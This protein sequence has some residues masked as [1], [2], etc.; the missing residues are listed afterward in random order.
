MGISI[1]IKET[2]AKSALC[3]ELRMNVIRVRVDDISG[4]EDL[5]GYDDIVSLDD[6]K[7]QVGDWEAFLK[8]NR[9]NAETDAIYMDKL[10]NEDDIK[11]LKPKAVRTSTG[12]IEMEKVSGAKKDKV[13]AASKKENRLTGWDMLSFEE[14]TEMCQKC[15]IS[16]DKGRGCIGTFGPNDSLLPS[17]AEKK[18]CKIIASVPDGAKSGR[19]YTPNEAK[20]LLKEIEILTAALP[21]EGKMMVRRYG[22]TLER[23]NAVANISVSE[24]CG[25]YFF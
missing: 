6:A 12:W 21:E 5:V 15:K 13:L 20:E 10:K 17:I 14:M 4:M 1:G 11:L 25:F 2:E 7:S 24:G 3:R 16:W 9:V 18:G 19:V 23:L 22:G 8:R